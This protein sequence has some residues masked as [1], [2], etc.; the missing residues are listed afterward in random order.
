MCFQLPEEDISERCYTPGGTVF[1]LLDMRDRK[2]SAE[3][4]QFNRK[5]VL[6]MQ[7]A[8]GDFK[9]HIY[10]YLRNSSVHPYTRQ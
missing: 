3:R 8:F 1:T 4:T 7:A 10:G 9:N 6:H 2:Q 5:N